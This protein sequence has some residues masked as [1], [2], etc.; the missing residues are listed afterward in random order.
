MTGRSTARLSRAEGCSAFHSRR[1]HRLDDPRRRAVQAFRSAP[2]S[3]G[4]PAG[5][6]TAH[7]RFLPSPVRRESAT[8]GTT[9]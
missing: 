6:A 3:V 4:L 2:S 1:D 5:P 7:G 9:R 8:K